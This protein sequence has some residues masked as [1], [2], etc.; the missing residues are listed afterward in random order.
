MSSKA[1]HTCLCRCSLRQFAVLNAG[2]K[3]KMLMLTTAVAVG[4][5]A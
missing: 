1:S 3:D 4:M 5:G 2:I